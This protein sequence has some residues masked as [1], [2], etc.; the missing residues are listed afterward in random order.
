MNKDQIDLFPWVVSKHRLDCYFV[1][2]G[3]AL[4]IHTVLEKTG[5][6]LLKPKGKKS[7]GDQ[8]LFAKAQS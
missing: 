2:I 8:K 1:F 6:S 7:E 5:G 3:E 4:D